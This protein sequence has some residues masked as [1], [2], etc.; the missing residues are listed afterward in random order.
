M[1]TLDFFSL[2]NQELSGPQVGGKY[3]LLNPGPNASTGVTLAAN[4]RSYLAYTYATFEAGTKLITGTARNTGTVSYIS[5]PTTTDS[6]YAFFS[7]YDG[8]NFWPIHA[9]SASGQGLKVINI[10]YFVIDL[11]SKVST[12][13][14]RTNNSSFTSTDTI[15]WSFGQNPAPVNFDVTVP[16]KLVFWG[17]NTSAGPVN[18]SHYFNTTLVSL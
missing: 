3:S 8:V 15:N 1:P 11:Q 5:L 12:C 13:Q 16:L 2:D 14:Y 6:V 18:A 7:L 17:D 10:L 9:S 4:N